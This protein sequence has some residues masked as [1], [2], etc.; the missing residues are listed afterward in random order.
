VIIQKYEH[1]EIPKIPKLSRQ[2]I[3]GDRH[4]VSDTGSSYPS[5]TTVLS[6]RDKGGI[7]AWRK[8][9]GNEE[10]N[11]IT[12]RATT[13]GTQF[14]SL[15]EQYFLNQITDVE[16]FRSNAMAKNPGVWYLFLEA[17]HELEE[18]IGKIYC[19]EDYL[20]SDEYGVAGAVDMIAEWDG[21][22]SVIDFKTSNSAKKE[23]W[24]E[25]YFIQGT[26]YA[27]MFTERTGI[28][29][30]QLIIFVV[31]DDGIPQTFTKRVDDYTELLKE[32]IRNYNV[33]KTKR[34]A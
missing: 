33:H 29:C 19:I 21:V 1:I 15:M 31:P 22:I 28:L 10:A 24:I 14:H 20:Y 16:E 30:E 34:A 13:R 5:I 17:I 2:N 23:E 26:G 6:I 11:R 9:V 7:Y 4:Y 25:N 27:K 18:K 32:A 8:R 3:A 12:K